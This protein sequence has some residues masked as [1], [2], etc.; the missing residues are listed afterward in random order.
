[1]P[2]NKIIRS[3]KFFGIG[4]KPWEIY[5]LTNWLDWHIDLKW[6]SFNVWIERI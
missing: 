3:L 1:M 4:F 2:P 6:I 5:R